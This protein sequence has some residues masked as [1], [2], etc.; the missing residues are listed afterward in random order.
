MGQFPYPRGPL[1]QIEDMMVDINLRDQLKLQIWEN[2]FEFILENL[3]QFQLPKTYLEGFTKL[4]NIS[5]K[6]FPNKINGIYT[7]N[8]YAN[9]D[10]FKIWAAEQVEIG[11]KLFIGQH[12]GNMGTALWDQSED[13]QIAIGDKYFSWG[14][15]SNE[16]ANVEP[17]SPGVLINLKGRIGYNASGHVLCVLNSVPRYF[18]CSYS[19]SVAGQ[20][21]D[22]FNYQVELMKMLEP[23]LPKIFRLR[24]ASPDFGWDLENRFTD[25]GF[26]SN[27]EKNNIN[28]LDRL[29]DCRL[30]VATNNGSVF[31][32]TFTA[33]F[34]TILYW[35]SNY[36]EIRDSAK[37]YFDELEKVGILHHSSKS[38]SSLIK[39][40]YLNPLEWWMKK[41]IQ[42]AKNRFCKRFAYVN[43]QWKSDWGKSIKN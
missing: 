37:E 30:C 15:K 31:L 7:A 4:K 6:K 12:G 29:S 42:S 22:Y 24:L 43:N 13:H 36:Y 23:E 21:L 27:I 35:D 34:P 10:G 8:A 14:W 32:E 5:M 39:K 41:E 17:L 33:N 26:G 2:E 16:H 9:D 11:T 40:I 1:V 18:Y 20:F 38:V 3:I 19:T 25:N 28:L